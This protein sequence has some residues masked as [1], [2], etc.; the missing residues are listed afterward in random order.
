MDNP[1]SEKDT[2]TLD[3]TASINSSP[4][5]TEQRLERSPSTTGSIDRASL[6]RRIS[7]AYE[8]GH[9]ADIGSALDEADASE[10]ES[11]VVWW[12]GDDD[13]QN[14]YNWP[15]WQK[16]VNCSLMS[17]MTFVTPL[18]SSIFAPGVPQVMH[19]FGSSSLTLAS[20]VVSVYLLGFAFGPLLIAPL[21][22]IYGRV[23]VY[24]VCH[25]IFTVFCVACALAPSLDALIVFRF[26]CGAFGCVSVTN[27]TGT[28][29]DMIK[30]EHRGLAISLFSIGPLLGPI[31]GPVAG[32]FISQALGWR[33]TFWVLA[34][35]GGSVTV[36]SFFFMRESY[37][38][39]ILK[40]KTARLQ[41]ETGNPL[42]RSRLDSGLS[43]ADFFKRGIIRPV[44]LLAKSPIVVIASL[45]MSII[46]GY[47]Y[48]MFTTMT[49]VF[50]GSYGF[51]T[52]TVGL[53]FLGLGAGNLIG[54]AAFSSTS[55][56]YIKRKAEED[57]RRAEETGQPKEGMKPEY[58]LPMLP[59][60]AVLV[61]VGLF[62]YGWTAQYRV[63]W[64]VPILSH[65][66][67]GVGN[68]VIFMGLQTYLVD[69]FT[70]YAA[71][72][73]AANTVVRSL[74]GAFLPLAGL[75]LFQSLGLGWGNSL[76]G[77]I[78]VAT[79]P[80]S[81]VLIKYG[82]ALRKRYPVKNL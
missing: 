21:S 2:T 65:V 6:Q 27:G 50:Q 28:V 82:E 73:V 74:F 9:D 15:L 81:F 67:I 78:A 25:A 12:D 58:R 66:P 35:L 4:A 29:A 17:I 61:P 52:G 57:D 63:H 48:L 8:E 41:K 79:I 11:L 64:I 33:W 59:L 1:T 71:S 26:F 31:I 20:F 3:G 70:V 19:E 53:A 56:K 24:H 39:V 18:G 36:V 10:D 14:P 44:K 72:A 40:H 47:L 30:Q 23:V 37:A 55:D 76:L 45:Y 32:G 80:V 54:L 62:I 68:L 42:L 34:M 69:C 16:V 43:P 46:Y 60:G 22:E 75:P 38:Y 49:T 51:S 5:K 7:Q 13:P 77:F